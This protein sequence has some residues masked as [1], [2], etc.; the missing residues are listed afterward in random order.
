MIAEWDESWHEAYVYLLNVDPSKAADKATS[1]SLKDLGIERVRGAKVIAVTDEEGNAIG[2]RW[3]DQNFDEGGRKRQPVSNVRHLRV[4]L[5]AAQYHVDT[6]KKNLFIYEGFNLLM[7][8]D[9]VNN[10]HPSILETLNQITSEVGEGKLLPPWLHDVFLGYGDADDGSYAGVKMKRYAEITPGVSKVTDYIDFGTAFKSIE[11]LKASFPDFKV[12]KEGAGLG[13]SL[14]FDDEKKAVHA[15]LYDTKPTPA[16]PKFT[17]VQV[18]AIRSG[19]SPGL[20]V[21]VGPPGTGKTDTAVSIITSLFR[22]FPTQRTLLVT[23]SNAALNDLF[24]K[25]MATGIVDERYMIRL[26]SGEK[27]LNIQSTHDFTKQ[28][29]VKYTLERR[30]KLLDEVQLLSESLGVSSVIERGVG[31]SSTY[32]C[33]T[34]LLFHTHHVKTRV[35]KFCKNVEEGGNASE[36]FPFAAYFGGKASFESEEVR[37]C[38]SRSV[39]Y[40]DAFFNAITVAAGEGN[41]REAEFDV[42]RAE[43]LPGFRAFA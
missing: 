40:S 35:Q 8:R 42:R 15:K 21:V 14:R 11:H 28:G 29:R 38:E 31:G 27:D 17:P 9:G 6:V 26:G 2:N 33:E 20:T 34:A 23:H 25:I 22:S 7:R 1:G 3:D 41:H 37:E 36:I 13:H 43:G 24:E 18:S 30:A 39:V 16:V 4:E 12:T 10:N 5:S 32:T 19:L